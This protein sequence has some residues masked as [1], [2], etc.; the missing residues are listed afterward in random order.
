MKPKGLTR[1]RSLVKQLNGWQRKVLATELAALV[2]EPA[3]V[4]IVGRRIGGTTCCPHCAGDRFVKNGRASG[5]QRYLCRQCQRTFNALTGTA[6]ARLHLRGKWL[7]QAQAL[8]DGLSLSAV[9]RQL[10]IAR[11]TAHRWRHRFLELP[12]S[13]RPQTLTGIAEADQTYFLQSP[14]GQR[15]ELERAPR[16]RG[17]GAVR[18]GLSTE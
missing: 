3:S 17:S 18:P 1:I 16:R 11:T 14:K 2:L 7:D 6:L 10:G 13:I 4:E 8:R 15:R 9:Q 12:R 5:L